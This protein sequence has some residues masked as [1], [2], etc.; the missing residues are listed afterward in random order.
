MNLYHKK[1]RWKIVLLIIAILLVAASLWFS[2][3]IVK[4]VAQREIDRVEQWADA[5]KRK[6]DLVNLTNNAFEELRQNER[7]KV[8]LWTTAMVE[9]NKDLKDYGLVVAIL[10]ESA[11]SFPAI[12]TD[13]QGNIKSIHN[14]EFLD[15]LILDSA[16]PNINRDTFLMQ[17]RQDSIARFISDWPKTHPPLQIN[18]FGDYWQTIYYYDSK[19]SWI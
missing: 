3:T 4:K 12:I 11:G 10:Q 2:N 5:V 1:Q 17:S 19:N 15:T 6:A 7:K 9:I 13:Q 16:P 18:L 8:E 14:L